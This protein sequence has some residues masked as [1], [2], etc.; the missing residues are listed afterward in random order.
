M[1]AADTGAP[2]TT[3]K[4]RGRRGCNDIAVA[5]TGVTVV[6]YSPAVQFRILGPLVVEDGST[7]VALGGHRQKAV[8]AR[9]L[10]DAGRPVPTDVLI[11]DVW[12]GRPPP[13]A[14]KTLHKYV[15]E[16]RR[17]LGATGSTALCTAGRGYVVDVDPARLDARRFEHEAKAAH[18]MA[19]SGDPAGCA[20]L[21]RA[22]LAR[23]RGDV[24]ADFPDCGF[25]WP[26]RTCLGELRLAL[27]EQC[28]AAEI[29]L[30]HATQASAELAALVELHPLRERLWALLMTALGTSGRVAEALRAFRR[31][32]E[33][34]GDELGLEPSAELRALEARIVRG[35]L[36]VGLPPVALASPPPPLAPAY[37]ITPPVLP[38]G[39][40]RTRLLEPALQAAVLV[41]AAPAGHGKTYLAARSRRLTAARPLVH[42]R[43]ARPRH[44]R[45]GEPPPGR[46]GGGGR[47]Q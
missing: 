16:L 23:W 30:G 21:G 8:L 1:G 33:L 38:C 26:L 15:S 11:E 22:A 7:T 39:V 27:T 14:A 42:R 37:K 32:G 10:V 29:E 44:C 47:G 6:A 2:A 35:E 20:R 25:A 17:A 28:L 3:D 5:R 24:L 45:R 34:L 31:F 12:D 41:L 43:R 46:A 40:E 13:T 9:L 19:S 18:A 36:P 4:A